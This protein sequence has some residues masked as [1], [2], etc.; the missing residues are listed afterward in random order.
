M[1]TKC[2]V[3]VTREDSETHRLSHRTSKVLGTLAEPAQGTSLLF[4]SKLEVPG[5][6]RTA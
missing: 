3:K 6:L 1:A 4:G 5:F 2:R